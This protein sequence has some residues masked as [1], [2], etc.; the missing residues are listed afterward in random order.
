MATLV[1]KA[2]KDLNL[3]IQLLQQ[4]GRSINWK[5]S[6]LR[7]SHQMLFLGLEFNTTT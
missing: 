5:K 2:Q 3:A 7:P 1:D 6:N 4:F